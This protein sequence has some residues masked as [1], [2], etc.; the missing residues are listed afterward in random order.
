MPMK[1]KLSDRWFSWME[2]GPMHEVGEEG[3]LV[4]CKF[5]SDKILPELNKEGFEV[6][7]RRSLS[8]ALSEGVGPHP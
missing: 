3:G 8:A 1:Q 5:L 7:G 2:E 4:S 6:P